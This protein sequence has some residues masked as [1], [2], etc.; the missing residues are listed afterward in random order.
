MIVKGKMTASNTRR[1]EF[2]KE[3]ADA[4]CALEVARVQVMN[5]LAER[6]AQVVRAQAAEN[7]VEGQKVTI[8]H[9]KNDVDRFERLVKSLVLQR[10]AAVEAARKALAEEA[11]ARNQAA[12]A[13]AHEKAIREDFESLVVRFEILEKQYVLSQDGN[14]D[15]KI[16][17]HE[18]L[19]KLKLLT[20]QLDHLKIELEKKIEANEVFQAENAVFE[21]GIQEVQAAADRARDRA[22]KA[23]EDRDEA[24]K[25]YH[26]SH[27]KEKELHRRHVRVKIEW[28]NSQYE[29]KEGQM[30]KKSL[31]IEREHVI[32][33][34]HYNSHWTK[35]TVEWGQALN[36]M[37]H[38]L[39]GEWRS[40][41]DEKEKA[42][43]KL[44]DTERK[45]LIFVGDSTEARERIIALDAQLGM[46][47]ES[48][49]A[50]EIDQDTL[51]R[52]WE[53]MKKKLK[54]EVELKKKELNDTHV[55]CMGLQEQLTAEKAHNH[56]TTEKLDAANAQIN[57][58]K[59]DCKNTV[60]AKEKE[61]VDKLKDVEEKVQ[62]R[63]T[64]Q[65]N[66]TLERTSHRSY[67]YTNVT[68]LEIFYGGKRVDD[69]AIYKNI[70]EHWGSSEPLALNKIFGDKDKKQ[71]VIIYRTKSRDEP[72]I[73]MASAQDSALK[74]PP[75]KGPKH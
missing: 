40:M 18:S 13:R 24:E 63:I 44:L 33:V 37:N 75:L 11:K 8:E 27:R 59:E 35:E 4:K 20:E 2:E 39:L 23:E 72:A 46:L 21:I 66:A 54:D 49:R 32:K 69:V 25:A 64:D 65:V 61:H 56:D 34:A 31:R 14:K 10:A 15:L 73:L 67:V 74:L 58:T 43:E 19:D 22:T 51:E 48:R 70:G 7:L 36:F 26:D 38:R 47:I 9:F 68:L 6:D 45:G 62:Q 28:E 12:V 5:V 53:E 41:Q 60:A 57:G 55:I 16:K 17:F 1:A 42:L 71:T 29:L 52:Q 50:S 3:L 30:R